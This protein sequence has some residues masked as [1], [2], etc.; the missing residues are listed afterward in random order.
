[1]DLSDE[2]R[3]NYMM[4]D[5]EHTEETVRNCKYSQ[6][7]VKDVSHNILGTSL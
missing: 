6:V 4:N 5:N 7:L 1:M 2:Q 3:D